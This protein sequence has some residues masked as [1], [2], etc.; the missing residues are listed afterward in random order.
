[1][2]VIPLV[3]AVIVIFAIAG[4][5]HRYNDGQYR[6]HGFGIS[7]VLLVVV[8]VFLLFSGFGKGDPC[9]GGGISTGGF[10]GCFFG[11]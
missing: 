3:A 5:G 4:A 10:F 1:M 6:R 8:M 9:R 7:G 11:K 2:I